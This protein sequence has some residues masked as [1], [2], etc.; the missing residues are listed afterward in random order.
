MQDWHIQ[1][2]RMFK[3]R[4]N[5]SMTGIE[6]GVVVNGFPDLLISLGEDILLDMDSLIVGNHLYTMHTHS[7]D[8][9]HTPV[10][11]A[12][13]TGDEVILMPTSNQQIYAVIDKVGI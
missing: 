8:E 3:D 13:M 4:N 12:L 1:L 5:Q 9:Y 11:T 6:I 10:Y 7:D 2:A